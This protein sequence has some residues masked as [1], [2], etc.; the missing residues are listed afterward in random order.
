MFEFLKRKPGPSA[1]ALAIDD[2]G[3]RRVLGDGKIE[4]VAWKDLVEVEIVTTDEG[5]FVDDVFFLLVGAEGTGCCVPQG[6]PGSEGLLD[7]LQGLPEFDNEKVIQAMGCAENARFVCWRKK[8][9]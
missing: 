6:A 8:S 4:A 3:V 9:A 7:R 1:P 5:P 2:V